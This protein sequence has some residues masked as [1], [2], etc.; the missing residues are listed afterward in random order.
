VCTRVGWGPECDVGQG[1]GLGAGVGNMRPFVIEC[2]DGDLYSI[3]S[4]EYRATART[5]KILSLDHIILTLGEFSCTVSSDFY[6]TT[7]CSKYKYN[8][9]TVTLSK[10]QICLE[11]S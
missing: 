7:L 6:P 8:T 1:K 11:C 2:T 3:I 4:L 9:Q 10:S 5:R